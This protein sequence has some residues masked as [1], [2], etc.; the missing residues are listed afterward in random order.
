MRPGRSFLQGETPACGKPTLSGLPLRLRTA[1]LSLRAWREADR[2]Y[3]AAMISALPPSH[4]YRKAGRNPDR[5]GVVW[6]L[7]LPERFVCIGCIGLYL[8]DAEAGA[9]E[10]GCL[11]LPEYGD[12]T[13]IAEAQTSVLEC[14]FGQARLESIVIAAADEAGARRVLREL[15]LTGKECLRSRP[16]HGR[17]RPD[18]P[19]LCRISRE[20][21]QQRYVLAERPG[22]FPAGPAR[23]VPLRPSPVIDGDEPR[24]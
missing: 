12:A 8:L 24:E 6:C 18:G 20:T 9:A 7:E 13:L 2:P 10:L 4:W 3:L 22:R 15:G 21:W 19:V 16:P 14:G 5:T 23:V 1:R 11:L 17:R